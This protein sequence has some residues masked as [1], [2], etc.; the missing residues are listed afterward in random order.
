MLVWRSGNDARKRIWTRNRGVSAWL[1]TAR[2]R[3]SPDALRERPA[4]ALSPARCP[5]FP[6]RS[7]DGCRRR[8]R[9]PEQRRPAGSEMIAPP[10][11]PGRLP[12]PLRMSRPSHQPSRN[13]SGR[14]PRRRQARRRRPPSSRRMR[15]H[16]QPLPRHHPPRQH[17]L[18]H[19]QPSPRL[20]QPPRRHRLARRAGPRK[21]LSGSQA[22]AERRLPRC[23]CRRHLRRRS[24]DGAR[25]APPAAAGPGW[26]A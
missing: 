2:L 5:F 25:D 8:S 24:G 10:S 14:Q 18:P 21:D 19:R 23:P 13:S 15:S 1:A 4:A 7:C 26:Q 9:P 16:R 3:R 12:R 11:R 6:T 17:R 20:H 22:P